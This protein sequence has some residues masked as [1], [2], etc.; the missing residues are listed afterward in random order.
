M[1]LESGIRSEGQYERAAAPEISIAGAATVLEDGR[2]TI[3]HTPGAL[4][5]GRGLFRHT[6]LSYSRKGGRYYPIQMPEAVDLTL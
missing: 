6:G 3:G 1:A 4:L 5:L 2:M